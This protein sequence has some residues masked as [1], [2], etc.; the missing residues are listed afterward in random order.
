MFGI[1]DQVFSGWS[2][3]ILY[4]LLMILMLFQTYLMKRVC[5]QNRELI[6]KSV[7]NTKENGKLRYRL[8]LVTY[9]VYFWKG[10]LKESGMDK[11]KM[12]ML[13][14]SCSEFLSKV[15]AHDQNNIVSSMEQ[16]DLPKEIVQEFLKEIF[17]ND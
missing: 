11:E 14:L 9:E 8:H 1:L 7:E 10:V 5:A 6:N 4:I 15:R 13:D 3:A 12:N 17:P 2:G 16:Q